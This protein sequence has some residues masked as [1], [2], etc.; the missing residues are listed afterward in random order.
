[1]TR[2][3]SKPLTQLSQELNRLIIQQIKPRQWGQN[4]A[5]SLKPQNEAEKV[6]MLGSLIYVPSAIL[7]PIVTQH[8]LTQAGIP[9]REKNLLVSQEWIRQGVGAAVHFLSFFTGIAAFG[10]AALSDKGKRAAKFAE[11]QA[12]KTIDPSTLKKVMGSIVFATVGNAWLRPTI[13]NH[14]V[15]HWFDTEQKMNTLTTDQQGYQWQY[16]KT[17]ASQHS[18]SPPPPV[19][20]RP[21]NNSVFSRNQTYSNNNQVPYPQMGHPNPFS[22]PQPF[23]PF[24][25]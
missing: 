15:K 7:T 5:R 16:F 17:L 19:E 8:Q 4:I 11:Q 1:M 13:L 22:K 3:F 20:L 21:I 9:Q 14:Y 6:Y 23:T 12:R 10:L 25:R 18:P 24:F 2:L